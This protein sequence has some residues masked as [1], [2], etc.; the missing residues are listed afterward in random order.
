MGRVSQYQAKPDEALDSFKRSRNLLSRLYDKHPDDTGLLFELGIAEYYIGNLHFAQ[1]RHDSALESNENYHRLTHAL[2]EQDPDNPDWILELSYSHNN[3]AA[4]HLGSGKGV[5]K[6]MLA[7]V[8]EALRLMEIVVAMKPD[9][10]AVATHYATTLAWA[11][12]AQLRACNL[13][14]TVKLRHRVMEL[15]EISTTADPGNNERRKRYAYALTGLARIQGLTGDP[16]AAV[17]NVGLAVSTLQALFAADPSNFHYREEAL[18]R[19]TMLARLL[20]ETGH[21]DSALALFKEIEVELTEIDGLQKQ[22][23][24]PEIEYLEF[25]L[26]YADA[27]L[28]QGNVAGAKNHLLSAIELQLQDHEAW[29]LDI[30][31]RQQMIQTRYLWWQM[32]GEKSLKSLPEIQLPDQNVS[33]DFRSCTEADS[34]ARLFVIEGQPERAAKEVKYLT[35]RGYADPSFIRFCRQH[36]LCG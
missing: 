14:E 2:V 30:Y 34:A 27:E 9:D 23:N 26:A 15:S 33:G 25:L 18:Y 8:A 4:I 31:D 17:E 3:L 13:E 6:K 10:Q 20:A 32:E 22:D 24:I 29:D 36:A 5:D 28:K 1:G 21:L 19:Q 35:D 16:A 12:D 11:A 7:N